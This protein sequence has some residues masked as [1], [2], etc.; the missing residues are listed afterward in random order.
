MNGL[1]WS[2]KKK[3]PIESFD[4]LTN[5]VLAATHIEQVIERE[6]ILDTS[7]RSL[8]YTI[9]S[10]TQSD[11]P[12]LWR[13]ISTPSINIFIDNEG[14]G[15]NISSKVDMVHFTGPSKIKFMFQWKVKR[16][17]HRRGV[18]IMSGALQRTR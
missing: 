13:N 7:T 9:I 14:Y 11:C 5:L 8:G 18:T 1:H 12:N 2:I 17:N 3:L 6:Q 16:K 15:Y 10:Q 4:F